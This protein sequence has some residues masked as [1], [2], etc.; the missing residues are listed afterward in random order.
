VPA[1]AR[2]RERLLKD[3]EAAKSKVRGPGSREEHLADVLAVVLAYVLAGEERAAWDFYE[4]AY[5]L[6]DKAKVQREIE[7][8]LR[9]QPV[10]RFIYRERAASKV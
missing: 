5:K 8:E 2:F 1:N 7:T 3:V 9:A 10:Y 6:P 4:A